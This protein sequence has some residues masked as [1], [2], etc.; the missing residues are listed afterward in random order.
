[1]YRNVIQLRP[2]KPN[3]PL[4]PVWVG[5]A[6]AAV[7][8][9]PGLHSGI[10]AISLLITPVESGA[11][12]EVAGTVEDGVGTVYCAGWVFPD[13]GITKYEVALTA[14]APDGTDDLVF[15][16]GTGI[17]TVL[18]ASLEGIN[19]VKPIIPQNSYARDPETGLYHLITA[20]LNEL[21][22]ITL[23]VATEGIENV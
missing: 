20:E 10:T 19:P 18:P 17:L 7:F 14:S 15:W 22:E 23:S 9:F 1:M 8:L 5:D 4:S 12:E 3:F 13:T 6:S 11:V 16:A 2:D 21:G